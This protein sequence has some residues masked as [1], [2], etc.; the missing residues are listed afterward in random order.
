MSEL[1]LG[2]GFSFV[3]KSEK[4]EDEKQERIV[5][6]G[7]LPDFISEGHALHVE[8]D[9][10]PELAKAY[11]ERTQAIENIEIATRALDDINKH[12]KSLE[13]DYK[14]KHYQK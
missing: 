6:L 7:G 3:P 13:D 10:P 4:T 9:A 8:S 1:G 11:A 12:I 14:A 2:L 5:V